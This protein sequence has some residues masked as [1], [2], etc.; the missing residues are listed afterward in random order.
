M[1]YATQL[2]DINYD[3]LDP[4]IREVVRRLND[5]L[6]T[7]TDSGDGASK[8]EWIEDGEAEDFPHVV[9]TVASDEIEIET[10]R[11]K[12]LVESWGVCVEPVGYSPVWIQATYDPC[13][14][15]ATIMLAGVSDAALRF[16]GV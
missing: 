14:G 15:L 9:I 2:G 6:F 12:N 5:A 7:T 1:T 16:E 4:G 11:L 3:D 8:V 10:N 13:D